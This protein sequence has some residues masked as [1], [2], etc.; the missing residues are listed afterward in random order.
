MHENHFVSHVEVMRWD[1]GPQDACSRC[2]KLR[3]PRSPLP[4]YERNNSPELRATPEDR[5]YTLAL[6]ILAP[7]GPFV[8]D[9]DSTF[10]HES[11]SR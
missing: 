2:G 10:V 9:P 8:R 3:V 5:T 7:T 1:N 6:A 4:F 11:G